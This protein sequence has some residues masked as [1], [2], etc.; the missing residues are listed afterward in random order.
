MLCFFSLF[1]FLH[2]TAIFAVNLKGVMP[3]KVEKYSLNL[4][5]KENPHSSNGVS[6]VT[7]ST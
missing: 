6:K 3:V 7:T 1:T 4:A 5:L 2:A